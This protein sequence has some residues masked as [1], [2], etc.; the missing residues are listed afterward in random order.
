MAG[1]AVRGLAWFTIGYLVL[2]NS[3]YLL[4]LALATARAARDA[5]RGRFA[6]LAEIFA[7]P[8][9]PAI[10]L[11][12]PVRDRADVIAGTTRGLLG[13]RYPRFEVIVVDDGSTDATFG[14]LQAEFGLVPIDKVIRDR[15][16]TAGRVLSV[17]APRDGSNLLVI[18]K[19]AA[20]R[21]ADAVRVGVNAARYPLVCSVGADT[22]LDEDALLTIAKPFIED[23][24]L[25][26]A[27]SAAI[28]V[29]N[30]SE[31]TRGRVTRP[32]VL[33]GWLVP[34]QAAEYLRSFLPGRAGWPGLG[35][36]LLLPGALAI[37]RRDVYERAAGPGP[38]GEAD[39]LELT[40]RIHRRLRDERQP[41]R[42]AFVPEPCCW[43][44]VPQRFRR[45]A[46]Q[47]AA[48]SG[49]LAGVLWAHRPMLFNP[50][51][52]RVG[53][54]VLPFYLIFELLSA[55]LEPLAMAAVAAGLAL[56]CLDP[57]VALLFA[58]AGPG[59]GAFL[60]VIGVAIEELGDHRYRSWRDFALLVH[61][62]VAE[63]AGFRQAHAWWRLRGVAGAVVRGGAHRAAEPGTRARDET[64]F[65]ITARSRRLRV[66]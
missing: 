25:V 13:L 55:V 3:G 9:A 41:Y 45:L 47:R 32:R 39:D 58:V 42:I 14:R 52:G 66:P 57:R 24:G 27:A 54:L 34:I 16:A 60:A 56:G 50:R 2:L 30:G 62:A 8:L 11:I 61:G 64:G 63:S 35:G 15:L 38:G 46:R 23:P 51:Y 21:A 28:R 7:S 48:W 1:A 17:H 31:I 43:T 4:L 5:R 6:G 59:Y 40:L 12:V 44:K 18:R 33:G 10:S 26:V 37:Y 53:L 36:T 20:G 19:H 49:A 22:Y 29:A 65:G